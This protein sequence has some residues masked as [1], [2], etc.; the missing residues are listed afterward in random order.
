MFDQHVASDVQ[1]MLNWPMT[2][3]DKRIACMNALASFFQR[4]G[5]EEIEAQ[6]RA[7]TTYFCQIGYYLIGLQ[8]E[9]EDRLVYLDD[10]MKILGGQPLDPAKAFAQRMYS[11]QKDNAKKVG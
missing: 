10:T 11:V 7:R 1:L 5:V 6:T 2:S 4:M 9:V 8:E 3:H